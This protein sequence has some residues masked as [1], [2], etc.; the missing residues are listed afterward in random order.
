MG[1]C[2][3]RDPEA[4]CSLRSMDISKS[5][6]QYL[7]GPSNKQL[8]WQNRR[9]RVPLQGASNELYNQLEGLSQAS[10]AFPISYS[11]LHDGA[12][13]TGRWR[14]QLEFL[15]RPSGV[16]GTYRIAWRRSNRYNTES[17]DLSNRVNPHA[18]Y[19]V[20]FEGEK[21]SVMTHLQAPECP[22]DV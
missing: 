21:N 13:P 1:V 7:N 19:V 20:I 18:V 15:G 3:V 14:K 22:V 12:P 11:I 6:S 8:P 9:G 17:M 4:I 16:S 2:T 5:I 10:R